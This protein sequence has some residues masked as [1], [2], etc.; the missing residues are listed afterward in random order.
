[1]RGLAKYKLR[2]RVMRARYTSEKLMQSIFG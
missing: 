2:H 1:M